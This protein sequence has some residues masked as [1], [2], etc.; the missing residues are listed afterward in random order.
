MPVACSYPAAGLV[1]QD[2]GALVES[3]RT[4]IAGALADGGIAAGDVAGSR[5]REPDRDVRALGARERAADPSRRSSGRIAAAPP[6]ASGSPRQGHEPLVRG[7]T[8]LELDATFPASKIRWLLEHVPGA[9]TRRRGGR[10]RLR[11][12][13]LL[14]RV[15]A[16]G[17]AT[18]VTDAGNAGRTMLCALGAH[19]LGRRAARPLRRARGAAAS[20]PRLRCRVRH[21]ARRAADRGRARR[22]AG[23]ALRAALL[24]ARARPRSRSA[25]AASC[26]CRPA[27]TRRGHRTACSRAPPG[28]ARARRATRSRGSFR[29]RARRSTGWRRSGCSQRR[30]SST[31]SSRRPPR[32]TS[33]WSSCPA[34]Q[35]LGTPSWRAETRGT[36]VGLSRGD[37]A[38]RDRARHRRRRPAPDRG[39]RGRDRARAA[40]R[41]DQARRRP[42]AQRLRRAA[43]RRP[44]GGADRARRRAPTRP[45]SGAALLAGLSA[46]LWPGLDELPP[47]PADL[48]AEPRALRARAVAAL[49]DRFAEVVELAHR[50]PPLDPAG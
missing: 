21:D 16:D 13:R 27:P 38:R 17:R 43:A 45:P 8:G 33:A 39:R 2:P 28:S 22:P 4:A 14:A 20:D 6:P 44:D 19:V 23:V 32:T 48:R 5:D 15:L 41:V 11:R 18:H 50:F 29:S 34:L 24:R 30:P 3:A 36:L 10:A 49:R 12:R 40:D 1:E 9:A 46:G 47:A 7:R 35:G 31:S 42:L 25:P 37:D 26:S